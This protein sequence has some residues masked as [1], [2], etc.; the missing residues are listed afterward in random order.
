MTGG[1]LDDAEVD[2]VVLP[3]CLFAF[4]DPE[5]DTLLLPL[6]LPEVLPTRL[7]DGVDADSEGTATGMVGWRGL[8]VSCR[9][10]QV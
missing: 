7:F 3:C 8:H 6:A 5:R 4:T 9:C 2:L 1:L 10:A